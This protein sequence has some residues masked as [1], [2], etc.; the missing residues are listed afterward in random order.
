MKS[1]RPDWFYL[2]SRHPSSRTNRSRRRAPL[3][4]VLY[5]LTLPAEDVFETLSSGVK[6]VGEHAAAGWR[7][8]PTAREGLYDDT[9]SGIIIRNGIHFC[10]LLNAE[11]L[12]LLQ[13][14]SAN[15]IAQEQLCI[16][17]SSIQPYLHWH[18]PNV[19]LRGVS[20]H[21]GPTNDKCL[22]L[23]QIWETINPAMTCVVICRDMKKQF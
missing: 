10:L 14:R 19:H 11:M 13:S 17:T 23:K 9:S 5:C 2:F 4:C 22:W 7:S 20:F 18:D 15:V 21:W 8:A 16:I 3:L 6:V 1:C 12:P